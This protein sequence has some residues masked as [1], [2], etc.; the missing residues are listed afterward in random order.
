MSLYVPERHELLHA[1]LWSEDR[2]RHTI[3]EIVDDAVAAFSPDNLFPAHPMEQ[4]DRSNGGCSHYIG[5]GGVLW[6]LDYLRRRGYADVERQWSS[7]G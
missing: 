4:L 6:A 5:A 1:E 2:A 3:T 7:T